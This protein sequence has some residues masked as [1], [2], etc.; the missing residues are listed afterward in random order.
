[1]KNQDL[2]SKRILTLALAVS[3]IL[4][5][6]ALFVF[7]LNFTGKAKAATIASPSIINT[8]AETRNAAGDAGFIAGV[9][10]SNGYAY[11]VYLAPDG[12]S[13]Y[14]KANLSMFKDSDAK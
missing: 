12:H 9:G 5:S 8:K 2:V 3:M 10:I 6:A 11:Y 1:M 4:C 14:W 13:N 7:S